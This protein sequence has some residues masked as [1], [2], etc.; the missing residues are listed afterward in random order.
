[1][2]ELTVLTKAM[3]LEREG[4]RFYLQAA[5]ASQDAETAGMFKT[6]AEDEEHHYAYIERQVNE[7]KA[8][9]GW[10]HIPELDQVKP[11]DAQAPIFPAGKQAPE[12]LAAKPSLEDA[13]LFG[14]DTEIKSYELYKNCSLEIDN[15]EAKQMFE[16]L[17]AAERGHF[18]TLMMR[19]ESHFGYPR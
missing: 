3:K 12:V 9:K 8:G 14:L 7:L 19:Y 1:M 6:L 4:K 2:D 16:K 15:P 17:A 5:E 13:L 10:V 18:D 11:V